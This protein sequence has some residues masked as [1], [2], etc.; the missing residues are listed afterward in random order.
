MKKA[1]LVILV[2]T[3]IF[4]SCDDKDM[5]EETNPFVGTWIDN[6]TFNKPG[7]TFTENYVTCFYHENE[8]RIIWWSGNYTYTDTHIIID[9]DYMIKGLIDSGNDPNPTWLYK[10][11]GK[12]MT[13]GIIVPDVFPY[14]KI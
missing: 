3:V 12:K 9:M 8:E 14:E 5:N 4:I 2:L 1:V 13:I 10:I 11:D 6:I 7:Y